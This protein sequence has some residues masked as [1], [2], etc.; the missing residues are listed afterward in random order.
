MTSDATHSSGPGPVGTSPDAALKQEL[1]F[2]MDAP[3]LLQEVLWGLVRVAA[4][5]PAPVP[6]AHQQVPSSAAGKHAHPNPQQQGSPPQPGRRSQSS[7]GGAANQPAVQAAL[8]A[9]AAGAD[10]A[11]LRYQQLFIEDCREGWDAATLL[12][13][14]QLLLEG[15]FRSVLGWQPARVSAEAKRD[16]EAVP[17]SRGSAGLVSEQLLVAE[18]QE[19]EEEGAERSEGGDGLE[20]GEQE[21]EGEVALEEPGVEE[22][23]GLQED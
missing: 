16:D 17:G 22:G 7:G 18:E 9:A 2:G 6:P 20:L 5:L 14:L 13:R 8:A 23:A 10:Q 1:L 21:D 3:L 11:L 4:L 12:P 19:E 15:A